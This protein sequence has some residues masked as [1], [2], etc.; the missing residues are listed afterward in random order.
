V[1]W[2]PAMTTLQALGV[3]LLALVV[4]GFL[5]QIDVGKGFGVNLGNG[6]VF[7]GLAIAATSPKKP[8]RRELRRRA[9]A[10]QAEE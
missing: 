7:L 10:Q 6:L 8:S 5:P 4:G 9:E 1:T 3:I 2:L